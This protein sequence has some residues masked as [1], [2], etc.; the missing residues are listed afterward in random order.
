MKK[1]YSIRLKRV[2][3]Y[4]KPLYQIIVVNK[5]N[6]F[7]SKLGSYNPFTIKNNKKIFL[8]K[9]S[10]IFWISKGAFLTSFLLKTLK[11]FLTFNEKN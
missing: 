10:V 8:N 5:N 6:K 9:F 11:I 1:L 7:I 3:R 2:G 4:K